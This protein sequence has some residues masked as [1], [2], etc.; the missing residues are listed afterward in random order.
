M[1]ACILATPRKSH[2]TQINGRIFRR[3]DEYSEYKRMIVDIVDNRS[4]L[5]SQL[6]KRMV[7]YKERDAVV[8]K[9]TVDYQSLMP[10]KKNSV[11]SF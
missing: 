6:S 2:A 5:K 4:I 8:D 7:A 1:T 10:Q 11:I 3:N 9:I